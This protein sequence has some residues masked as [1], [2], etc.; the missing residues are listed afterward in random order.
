MPKTDFGTPHVA[1]ANVHKL[2]L[3]DNDMFEY[4]ISGFNSNAANGTT[5]EV[6]E[7]GPRVNYG[8]SIQ[9]DTGVHA[10]C[11]FRIDY[12]LDA[13]FWKIDGSALIFASG[14]TTATM[15]GR[16][17]RLTLIVQAGAPSTVEFK[18]Q[19]SE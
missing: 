19:A 15:P 3:A 2:R 12:S 9:P 13:E 10:S 16:Y 14:M 4:I 18:L 17:A 8:W 6:F 11:I 5:S 7:I 1:G